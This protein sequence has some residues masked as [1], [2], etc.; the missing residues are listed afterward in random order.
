[1][2]EP[3][4]GSDLGGIRTRATRMAGGYRLNGQKMWVTS[5]PVADFFTVFARAGDDEGLTIFFG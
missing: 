3:D 2:T 1:M 5:A 4:A